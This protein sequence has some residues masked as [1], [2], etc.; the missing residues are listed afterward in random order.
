MSGNGG[1]DILISDNHEVEA[2][3]RVMQAAALQNQPDELVRLYTAMCA[4]GLKPSSR[5]RDILSSCFNSG[6]AHFFSSLLPD[7]KL[8]IESAAEG[9]SDSIFTKELVLEAAIAMAQLSHFDHAAD[10]FKAMFRSDEYVLFFKEKTRM[11]GIFLLHPPPPYLSLISPSF[12]PSLPL[13]L[14]PPH[15][16]P[17]HTHSHL[18]RTRGVFVCANVLCL[19]ACV[20]VRA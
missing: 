11:E 18:T 10:L 2:C 5:T 6:S 20:Y 19:R 1:K 9:A 4:A 16:H 15:A 8:G 13:T 7:L 14:S 12:L 17:S 3:N